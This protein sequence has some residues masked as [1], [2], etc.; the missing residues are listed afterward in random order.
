MQFDPN[1][2]ELQPGE[3]LQQGTGVPYDAYMQG[4]SQTAGDNADRYAGAYG[5]PYAAAYGQQGQGMPYGQMMAMDNA[6][7][8]QVP[9][10][11]DPQGGPYGQMPYGQDPQNGPYGQMP[12]GQNPQG[13]AP[14][15]QMPEMPYAQAPQGGWVFASQTPSAQ[16]FPEASVPQNM[17]PASSGQILYSAPMVPQEMN[18]QYPTPQ[19]AR[20]GLDKTQKLH[21]GEKVMA[22]PKPLIIA[23]PA[24]LVLVLAVAGFFMFGMRRPY[25]AESV[26]SALY[27]RSLPIASPV[28]Y[29]A[30]TDP[31][32]LLGKM[33]QYTSKVSWTDTTVSG[34]TNILE[35]GGI[36]EVF[37]TAELAQARLRQLEAMTLSQA[38]HVSGAN[39]AVMR[40]SPIMSRSQADAYEEALKGM[41]GQ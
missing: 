24:V 38:G 8:S 27:R 2:Q 31:D 3:G 13:E 34:A 30:Q 18:E 15:G 39:R 14:Y 25:T 16:P 35:G 32:G 10:G 6:S 40:L 33:N 36:V 22:N 7:Y 29:T 37:D 20:E 26:V 28:T 9:S 23:L 5:N 11:Q 41:F 19:M 12:Y 4:Q 1:G 17:P 21:I